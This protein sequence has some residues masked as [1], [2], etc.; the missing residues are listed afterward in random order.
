MPT[1]RR[2]RRAGSCLALLA[3]PVAG[4][5][6]SPDAV[7]AQGWAA[8][9][10]AARSSFGT[11]LLNAV[12]TNASLGLRYSR[13]RR[14]LHG[15]VAVPLQEGNLTWGLLSMGDRASVRRGRF[16]AGVD[17]SALGHAQRDPSTDLGGSGGR[18]EL[19]PAISASVGSVVAEL[20]SGGSWYRG[21]LGEETWTRN[22]H[23]TDLAVSHLRT[24]ASGHTV[25]VDG[26]V[27]HLRAGGGEEAYS[28]AGVLASGGGG[29]A[30]WWASTG[31]W[32]AGLDEAASKGAVG[33]G[34]SWA[35]TP[36]TALSVAVRREP[37]DPV[38]LGT[39]RTSWG[40]ALRHSLGAPRPPSP[41]AGADPR[42]M[43]RMVLR[44]PLDASPHPPG[45][46]GDFT[47][48]ELRPMHRRGHYWEAE[49][50]V[51]PGLYHYAFQ[52]R[53]GTWFVPADVQG[54]RDDGMGGWVAV[55][56]V[57][58]DGR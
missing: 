2:F 1:R 57:P 35:L 56:L 36:A 33:G 8:E 49:F 15:A 28:W 38:F 19:L 27:R 54:R 31:R 11:P 16:E 42:S 55:L 3:F 53:D 37:F 43:G 34:I 7:V 30:T 39:D 47:N 22:L 21:R 6:A 51:A 13:D 24:L 26:E 25:R 20:R 32:L 44:L 40:T 12:S 10:Q 17:L 41:R 58:E 14:H 4:G 45:V 50:V 23:A 52:S 9:V 18:V 48:W 46:A 29:R 5:L